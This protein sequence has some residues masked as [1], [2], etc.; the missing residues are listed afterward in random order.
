MHQRYAP[1][2]KPSLPKI[3]S[4]TGSSRARKWLGLC[5]LK[6]RIQ[7]ARSEENEIDP[8]SAPVER[9]IDVFVFQK[10]KPLG[11]SEL[12]W[13]GIEPHGAVSLMYCDHPELHL[14][15]RKKA[16]LK[17]CQ[18]KAIIGPKGI[19]HLLT[20]KGIRGGRQPLVPEYS[21]VTTREA[22][23][24]TETLI[25]LNQGQPQVKSETIDVIMTKENL[26]RRRPA[27][28]KK[29]SESERAYLKPKVKRVV[30]PVDWREKGR[31]EDPI[32][33]IPRAQ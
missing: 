5:F 13:E 23:T 4:E 7:K 29:S 19:P 8:S 32:S 14:C 30:Q 2:L 22:K 21:R 12:K 25:S 27:L 6:K 15:F 26:A 3:E 20:L 10:Q 16:L 24:E 18:V 33:L 17:T 11:L 28:P 31:R 1:P 9:T